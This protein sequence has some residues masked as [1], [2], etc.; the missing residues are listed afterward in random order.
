MLAAIKKPKRFFPFVFFL[1]LVPIHIWIIIGDRKVLASILHFIMSCTASLFRYQTYK[2]WRA[3]WIFFW[4]YSNLFIEICTCKR[5]ALVIS[6]LMLLSFFSL[7]TFVYYI[8][9]HSCCFFFCSAL[10]SFSSFHSLVYTLSYI[11]ISILTNPHTTHTHTSRTYT[12]THTHAAAI[13]V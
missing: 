8:P 4:N 3:I 6:M 10:R 2:V 5:T 13:A 1:F 12:H 9:F 11:S 7:F